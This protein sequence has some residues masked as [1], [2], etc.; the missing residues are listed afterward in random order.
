MAG[1]NGIARAPKSDRSKNPLLQDL[2]V[3]WLQ[4]LRNEAPQRVMD[5]VT[6][7]DGTV[8]DVIRVGKNGDYANLDAVVMD[9]TNSMIDPM[10]PR[11]P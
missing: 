1:Y 5:S 8:S 9:A 7:E 4:K 6:A 3:G 2:T 11:R 10:A